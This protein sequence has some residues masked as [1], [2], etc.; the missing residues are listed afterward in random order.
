MVMLAD[1]KNDRVVAESLRPFG[2]TIF[3]EMTALANEWGAVNLS[4][5]FPDFDGPEEIRAKAAKAIMRGPNQY[6]PSIGIPELRQAVARKM[7]RFYG[8]EVDAEEEVTVTSG[9][10]EGLCATMLGILE[11]GDEIMLYVG[12]VAYSYYTA[13]TV[14][15]PET[16]ASAEQRADNLKYIGFVPEERLT[17]VTCTPPGLATHRLLVIAQ[18]PDQV[19]PQMPEAGSETEP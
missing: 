15:L 17:L 19:A 8:L 12:D 11:P 14:I 18:P 5:G 6:A 3:S 1:Q 2:T 16:F 4:Q 10:T 9:A 7:K 13:E